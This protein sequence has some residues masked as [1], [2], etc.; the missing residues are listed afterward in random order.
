MLRLIA[1]Q[2]ESEKTKNHS[3]KNHSVKKIFKKMPV[4]DIC[5]KKMRNQA[6]T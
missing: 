5:I 1:S 2:S 6:L 4:F 3:V